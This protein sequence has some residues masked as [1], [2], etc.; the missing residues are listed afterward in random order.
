M[1][2]GKKL[3]LNNLSK[4]HVDDEKDMCF[5]DEDIFLIDNLRDIPDNIKK[6]FQ[7]DIMV[8][9]VC[10]AGRLQVQINGSEYMLEKD[11]L[12]ICSNWHFMTNAMLSPDFSCFLLGLSREKVDSITASLGASVQGIFYLK[13][14]PL[15]KLLPAELPTLRMYHQI[16][17][18][19]LSSP[20]HPYYGNSFSCL[21]KSAVYDL[22]A[23]VERLQ[24]N[25]H[26]ANTSAPD[27]NYAFS[28]TIVRDFVS[29]LA[30]DVG[31]SRSVKYYADKLC[32][33]SKYL[34]AVCSKETGKVPSQWIKEFL[35][36][37]IRYMLVSTNMSCKEIAI[38]L[39]FPNTSFFGKFTK[40]H[41]GTSPLAYRKQHKAMV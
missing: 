15:V 24:R 19:K 41:L 28:N 12:L 40:Q 25:D 35:V 3:N 32:I 17:K 27:S 20:R 38:E 8:F 31:N 34:S 9:I 36:E 16:L 33:T 6:A 5:I 39:S 14:H 2:M 23:V 21:M 7:F 11:N 30:E 10:K 13:D 18:V 22:L 1:R 29:M 37:R 26:S 4:L